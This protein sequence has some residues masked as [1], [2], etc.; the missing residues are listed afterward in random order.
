M[1]VGDRASMAQPWRSI[2]VRMM[3][4]ESEAEGAVGKSCESEGSEEMEKEKTW[5][6]VGDLYTVRRTTAS[7]ALWSQMSSLCRFEKKCKM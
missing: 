1:V 4:G 6:V 2:C 3:A 5:I 7:R